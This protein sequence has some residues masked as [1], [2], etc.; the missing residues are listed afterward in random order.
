MSL[1]VYFSDNNSKKLF[2][3]FSKIYLGE[4]LESG[5]KVAVKKILCHS[6]SEIERTYREVAMHRTF[7]TNRSGDHESVGHIM[8]I[9]AVGEERISNSGSLISFSLIF[10]LCKVSLCYI[11]VH[12]CTFLSCCSSARFNAGRV[13]VTSDDERVHPSGENHVFVPSSLHST[14]SF[15]LADAA[16]C[17]PVIF[18]L[19]SMFC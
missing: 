6:A 5:K 7:T 1:L 8:Q 9:I 2:R 3:G 15:T 14:S 13:D 11:Y 17:P 10:P 19:L 18:L 16:D 12:I 4:D